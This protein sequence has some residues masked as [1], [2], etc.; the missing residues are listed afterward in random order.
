MAE[1][2]LQRLVKSEAALLQEVKNGLLS[3]DDAL[4]IAQ[5][6]GFEKVRD[7]LLRSGV[8]PLNVDLGD[9]LAGKP[10]RSSEAPPRCLLFWAAAGDNAAGVRAVL[11]EGKAGSVDDALNEA[12]HQHN[13]T[14]A[15]ALVKGKVD[16]WGSLVCH[17]IAMGNDDMFQLLLRN[18]KLDDVGAC[19]VKALKM[20]QPEM[21]WRL[22]RKKPPL[23]SHT[24]DRILAK[25]IKLDAL[26][27]IRTVSR[28]PDFT[29]ARKSVGVAFRVGN[30]KLAR[31]LLRTKKVDI[32]NTL[33]LILDSDRE[34]KMRW[35]RKLLRD[36]Q[37]KDIDR[38]VER[39][40][41]KRSKEGLLFAV[42]KVKAISP[43][44]VALFTARST[45]MTPEDIAEVIQIALKKRGVNKGLRQ[46]YRQAARNSSRAAVTAGNNK[47]LMMFALNVANVHDSVR[48]VK[49][50]IRDNPQ[51]AGIAGV[52]AVMFDRAEI[53][54]ALARKELIDVD[55]VLYVAVE[56][57]SLA[58]LA[59]LL[60]RYKGPSLQRCIIY[61]RELRNGPA[62]L[63]FLEKL[64]K[65]KEE[66]VP[67]CHTTEKER[68]TSV[69]K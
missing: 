68:Y 59:A 63:M 36:K 15:K 48:V 66:E 56:E 18:A 17:S 8:N 42:A 14:A 31:R 25:G 16:D 58:S 5:A 9:A 55:A 4:V 52:Q 26:K 64:K 69:V 30:D 41:K 37:L 20:E 12:I 61:A 39:L 49:T 23:D 65:V 10:I 7:D 28:H 44:Q 47:E 46:L 24:L 22:W 32:E 1:L 11:K 29:E 62:A 67:R 6:A 2:D 35:V 19:L 45:K 40:V 54:R 21:F 50:F 57:D 27:V 3:P 33:A 53:V 34:D 13:L 60:E 51:Q 38:V 43:E